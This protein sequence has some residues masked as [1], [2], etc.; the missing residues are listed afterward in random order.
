MNTLGG[1]TSWSAVDHQ[2]KVDRSITSIADL[3]I[4]L[5]SFLLVG[6]QGKSVVEIYRRAAQSYKKSFI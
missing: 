2:L 3:E 5:P 1:Y 4:C 6:F